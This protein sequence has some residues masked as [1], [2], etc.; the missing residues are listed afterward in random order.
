MLRIK[1]PEESAHR[2]PTSSNRLIQ[3]LR[4]LRRLG[5][6][7]PAKP[8]LFHHLPLLPGR[9]RLSEPDRVRTTGDGPGVEPRVLR[10]APLAVDRVPVYWAE[11]RQAGADDGDGG[12][13]ECPDGGIGVDPTAVCEGDA[14][15][16]DD[17]DDAC[18]ADAVGMRS[19]SLHWTV[20]TPGKEKDSILFSCIV[21][22][23]VRYREERTYNPPSENMPA[24]WIL[25]AKELCSLHKKGIGKPRMRKSVTELRTPMAISSASRFTQWALTLGSQSE[26]TGTHWKIT[27][28]VPATV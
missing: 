23:A 15:D 10:E 2:H 22:Q 24:S 1:L 9:C 16:G 14:A 20:L 13:D 6:S 18:D 11:G 5:R 4:T 12:L 28:M 7:Q 21:E 26:R 25:C 3:P 27:T 19:E 17:S 8:P